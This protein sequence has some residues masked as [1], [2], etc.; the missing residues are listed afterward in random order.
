LEF[1]NWKIDKLFWRSCKISLFSA[2]RASH[3]FMSQTIFE[4]IVAGTIP[5]YKLY[6]D[7]HV[8]AILDIFPAT[9]VRLFFF[10]FFFAFSISL[11]AVHTISN[12]AHDIIIYVRVM[13]WSSR[14]F[15]TP[16][17]SQFLRTFLLLSLLPPRRSLSPFPRL[18]TQMVSMLFKI[19]GLLLARRSRITTFM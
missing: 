10:L 5:C 16:I 9:K 14:S 17:S 15:H 2:C 18:S 12:C 4:K 7:E 6:E 19:T 8:I 3:S 13:H 1:S 11:A